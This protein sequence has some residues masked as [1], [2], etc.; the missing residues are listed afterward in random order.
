M[1]RLTRSVKRSGTH[2]H[3]GDL[4]Q[5]MHA[6]AK[7]LFGFPGCTGFRVIAI[8]QAG[9][10]FNH[11]V[12]IARHMGGNAHLL[13]QQNGFSLGIKGQNRRRMAM[14]I[15]LADQNLGAAIPA[16]VFQRHLAQG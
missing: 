6:K 7:L 11:G 2:E 10:D 13:D 14:V 4:T 5:I 1:N 8:K 9:A 3:V 15:D 12:R 16:G